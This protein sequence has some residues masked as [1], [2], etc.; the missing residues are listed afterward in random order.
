MAGLLL[1][2]LLLLATRPSTAQD[3]PKPAAAKKTSSLP[4]GLDAETRAIVASINSKLAERWKAAKV[5]PA[6]RA[7]DYEFLRRAFLDLIGRIA[8]PDEI[9]RFLKDP[10]ETRRSLLIER[11]LGT[12]DPKFKT[13]YGEEYAKNWA[14]IWTV[15]LLTRGGALM[16]NRSDYHEQMNGWLQEQFARDRSFKELVSELL[17]ATGPTT[18]ENGAVNFILA[19]LGEAVPPGKRA[20]EGQFEMVPITSRTTRLFLGLQIQ[21]VQ[22]HDH[23]FNDEWKQE[24]FWGVNAFFRQVERKGRPAGPRE[25]ATLLEL[26]DNP[27]FNAEGGVF[28]ETRKGLL[29]QTKTAFPGST[30]RPAGSGNRRQELA[31]FVTE[32]EF[33]AK[34]YVNRMWGHCFG[35]GLNEQPAVDDFGEHNK[36]EHPE[37]LDELARQFVQEG[38][39]PKR[40]LRWLCHSDAYQLSSLA[41]KTND[42]PE[43]DK[44][45]SRMLLKAMTP[46]QLFESLM[47]ATQAEAGEKPE[48]RKKLR[49]T[50]LRNLIVNFGDD[51]GNE[52]TF[53]GTVVQAL[54]LMN[55][56]EINDAILGKEKGTV[57][58]TLRRRG[59]PQG[60]L[61]DLYLAALNRPPTAGE[62]ARML[63]ILN[64]APVRNRDPVGPWQDLF[65]ALLNSSEF[66]LNH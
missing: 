1:G 53:N 63:R 23:P 49:E 61:N 46:E 62:A 15:W 64:T 41:N 24:H 13:R 40:L 18:K 16:A 33:F 7:T 42:K 29:L 10:P 50:W 35:R 28:Y 32:N 11:L 54:L 48:D 8:R 56:K 43:D 58:Q 51:E 59:T 45:F 37:L 9:Q 20:E 6:A 38:Y 5:T 57:A 26:V 52:V 3:V 39:S 55:G 36:V 12:E 65:W 17:T 21:C 30:K 14:N 47:V 4:Q 22:C 60:V 44:L 27:A 66:I 34:A 31:R 19:H 25:S 2:S